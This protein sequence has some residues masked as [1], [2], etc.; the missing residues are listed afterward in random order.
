MEWVVL[1]LVALPSFS[2][3]RLTRYDLAHALVWLHLGLGSIRHAP[4]FALAVAPGLAGLLDGLPLAAPRVLPAAAM[5]GR[6]GRRSRPWCWPW[7]SDAGRHSAA[8]TR[9]PGRWGRSRP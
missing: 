7:R 2:R 3:S 4:L 9:R 5:A 1:A 6:R 8:S